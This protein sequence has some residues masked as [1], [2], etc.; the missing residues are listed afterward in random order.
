MKL[1]DKV[2]VITG[3]AS[4]IGR[5]TAKICAGYGAK[6]VAWDLN[7]D[8]LQKT[9]DLIK[10]RG[11]E[12][13]FCKVD[14]TNRE[15]VKKA[16]EETIAAYG[17][18]DNLFSNA[19]IAKPCP[20]LELTDEEYDKTMDVNLKGG[21]IVSTEVAKAMIPNKKGR[22]I[23][24]SSMAAYREEKNNAAYCMSKEALR[25]M[26]KVMALELAPYGITTVA[27]AP[28]HVDTELLRGAFEDRGK[29]ENKSVETFYDEMKDLIAIGRLAQPEEIGEFVA[30]LCDDRSSYFDGCS[31]LIAGGRIMD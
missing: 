25:M 27:I 30:Y 5:A 2:I 22:I 7:E 31:F 18:I 4:G 26:M 6:I 23:F 28:G 14:V 10:E 19:G 16:V 21:F 9:V 15:N 17:N 3:A 11:G 29:A 1:Q 20:L 8:G 12:A 24:T 13:T